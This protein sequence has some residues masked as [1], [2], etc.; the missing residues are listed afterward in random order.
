[1]SSSTTYYPPEL[2]EPASRRPARTDDAVHRS[3]SGLPAQANRARWV[4]GDAK[5]VIRPMTF[6]SKDR[7]FPRVQLSNNFGARRKVGF[8]LDQIRSNGEKPEL[9]DEVVLLAKKY[10]ITTPYTSWLIVP[11]APIPGPGGTTRTAC[12]AHWCSPGGRGGP[13][14]DQAE[15]RLRGMPKPLLDTPCVRRATGANCARQ[16]RGRRTRRREQ[17]RETKRRQGSGC[18]PRVGT[19]TSS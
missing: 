4:G 7:R 14:E 16:A 5:S 15:Q 3:G 19:Q 18:D 8:L 2:P 12:P 13:A 17:E 10:G 6:P 1:M 11:D 9:K